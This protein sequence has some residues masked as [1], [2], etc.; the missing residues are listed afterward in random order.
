[1]THGSHQGVIY[2]NGHG[3]GSNGWSFPAP[4]DRRLQRELS[5]LS[6]LHLFGGRATFG[7]RLDMDPI[8]QPDVIGDAWAPPFGKN[9][10]DAV[11]LDPPYVAFGRHSREQ[12]GTGAAWIARKI[13][14]WF[15]SFAAT[16]LPGCHIDRWWTV[17]IGND[18]NI[19]QLAYFRPG[20]HKKEPNRFVTRGPAMKYNRWRAGQRGLP[21]CR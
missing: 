12:L 6:V 21:L 2:C 18:C 8:T 13:V 15:S 9:S 11:V 16:S 7:V 3:G 19:R 5:G 20:E 17:I 4:I 10:F 1:V 14:V